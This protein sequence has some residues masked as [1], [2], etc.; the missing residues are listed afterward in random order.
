MRPSTWPTIGPTRASTAELEYRAKLVELI[1]FDSVADRL[2]FFV[3]DAADDPEQP[4]PFAAHLIVNRLAKRVFDRSP[5]D[6]DWVAV[7]YSE[8]RGHAEALLD[9]DTARA[10]GTGL[11]WSFPGP[12]RG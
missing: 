5:D 4:H 11:N 6:A 2:R 10:D 1:G 3:A 8:I 7:P 9:E 12:H